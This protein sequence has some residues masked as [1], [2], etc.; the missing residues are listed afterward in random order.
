MS[1]YQTGITIAAPPERV[2]KLL[3]EPEQ[4]KRWADGVESI[5]YTEGSPRQAGARFK[6]RIKEGSKIVEYDGEVV[7]YE[8]PRRHTTRLANPQFTM[9]I[10]HHLSAEGGGTRV[11]QQ[12]DM[13]AHSALGRLLGFV[14]CWFTKGISRKQLAKVKELAE[15]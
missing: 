4:I 8:P 12:V 9:V 10:D 7:A 15:S 14:F 2:F 5:E 6:Q 13:T 1:S 3:T 11:E